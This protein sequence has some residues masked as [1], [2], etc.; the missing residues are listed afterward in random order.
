M[1]PPSIALSIAAVVSI[2]LVACAALATKSQPR[3]LNHATR[4][5]ASRI[6]R[7]GS[8]APGLSTNSFRT[9]MLMKRINPRQNFA[10]KNREPL[11][12]PNV[13]IEIL[14]S[15]PAAQAAIAAGTAALGGLVFALQQAKNDDGSTAKPFQIPT[16]K[17]AA[18]K[19]VDAVGIFGASG[20]TGV[21]VVN[22]II[23]DG[24]TV[25]GYVRD[26]A[27]AKEIFK[28]IPADKLV[29]R[30]LDVTNS[31]M[32]TKLLD[33]V[34]QMVLALGP[35]YEKDPETGVFGPVNGLTPEAVDY[36]GVSNL[37]EIAKK[38]FEQD[39][40]KAEKIFDFSWAP[41][42][43]LDM[44]APLDDVIMGGSSQSKMDFVGG[45]MKWSG[46]V[47]SEGGGFCGIRAQ[48]PEDNKVSLQDA[49]A[50]KLLVRGDGNRYKF[51]VAV[52]DGTRYQ[53]PFDTKK[54]FFQ[55]IILPFE[56]FVPLSGFDR[57][58]VDYN[59][60]LL[61]Q[62]DRSDIAAFNFVCSKF[63][64]NER[65][66]PLG[67]PTDFSL[68]IDSVQAVTSPKPKV[69]IVTSASV[70]RNA[71]ITEEERENEIPIVK[72]NPNGI[73]NWKYKGEEALRE[74]GLP[75]SVIRPTGLTSLNETTDFALDVVQGDSISGQ[76]SRKEVASVVAAALGSTAATGKTVELRRSEARNSVGVVGTDQTRL[77]KQLQ[78]AVADSDRHLVGLP[79]MAKAVDPPL[80]LS[81]E[82]QEEI[83]N[84]PRVV[85]QRL[86]EPNN[87]QVAG[88]DRPG[89]I[90]F[91]NGKQVAADRDNA[92]FVIFRNGKPA[93]A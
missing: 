93:A 15:T 17:P 72:L 38:H 32:D 75:Y 8:Q 27:K 24:K 66:N 59:A 29:L 23:G 82:K 77:I 61:S 22:R 2:A 53:H 70:E 79:I 71:R 74:S 9:G 6:S 43:N 81:P 73:L 31:E 45:L 83:L 80:A 87:Q 42:N 25:V 33:G 10:K 39:D 37:V 51:T 1:R 67:I 90:V 49:T 92:G 14:L 50:I 5:T 36:K 85:A 65:P 60:P 86:R 28:D 7:I 88:R 3:L 47:V 41:N 34:S 58:M 54:G 62:V 69:V 64:F 40:E 21:E 26:V 52:R 55:E 56:S 35:V 68:S 20:Q 11:P 44:W 63:E 89:F 91:R 57:N 48:I 16:G 46:T 18:K 4:G 78:G 13:G 76:I 12:T 19:L 30:E 84:D